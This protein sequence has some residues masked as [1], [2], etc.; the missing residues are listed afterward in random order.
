MFFCA[1]DHIF[2]LE[3]PQAFFLLLTY[4]SHK[5]ISFTTWHLNMQGIIQ[6][7]TIFNNKSNKITNIP[8]VEHSSNI[9]LYPHSRASR[10]I[11]KPICIS[12]R[13]GVLLYKYVYPCL[14]CLGPCFPIGN[15]TNFSQINI[16]LW[17][18][19]LSSC[20]HVQGLSLLFF[21]VL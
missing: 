1:L 11:N 18:L 9:E 2:L 20:H 13:K 16:F 6:N 21:C 4:F 3:T 12:P 14:L 17:V 5:I 8:K 7:V 10:M 19:L 15:G